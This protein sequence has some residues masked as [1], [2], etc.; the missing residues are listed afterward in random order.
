MT[1]DEQREIAEKYQHCKR[2]LFEFCNLNELSVI[3]RQYLDNI[4]ELYRIQGR[5]EG[6]FQIC[7]ALVTD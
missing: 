1:Q 4:C 2:E 5:T 7:D 3:Q 6:C